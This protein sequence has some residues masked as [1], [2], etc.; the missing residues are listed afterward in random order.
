MWTETVPAN[1]DLLTGFLKTGQDSASS[2]H[3]VLAPSVKLPSLVVEN[4]SREVDKPSP[5]TGREETTYIRSPN[6]AQRGLPQV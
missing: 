5:N 6:G 1:R 4:A 2:T 3:D